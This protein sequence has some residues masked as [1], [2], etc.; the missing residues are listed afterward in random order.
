MITCKSSRFVR[1]RTE[2]EQM[3]RAFHTLAFN[4]GP[5]SGEIFFKTRLVSRRQRQRWFANK[6]PESFLTRRRDAVT[7]AS[8]KYTCHTSTVNIS[9][10]PA[11]SERK[12]ARTRLYY[13]AES[14]KNRVFP[15]GFVKYSIKI[16]RIVREFTAQK[17]FRPPPKLQIDFHPER[18]LQYCLRMLFP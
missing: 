2:F 8:S 12:S 14:I 6:E 3:P 1:W 5:F 9:R 7:Y 15:H 10:S 16:S 17:C 13:N 11:L 18:F 4:R